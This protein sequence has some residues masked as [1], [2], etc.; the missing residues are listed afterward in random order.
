MVGNIDQE[1]NCSSISTGNDEEEKSYDEVN[2]E[3]DRGL[4]N[5]TDHEHSRDNSNKKMRV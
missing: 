1:G 3:G 2:D 4:D 5:S